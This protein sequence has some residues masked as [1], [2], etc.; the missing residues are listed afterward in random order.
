VHRNIGRLQALIEKVD[1]E[2]TEAC[3]EL[4]QREAAQQEFDYLQVSKPEPDD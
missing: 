4:K 1:P 3:R 2:F